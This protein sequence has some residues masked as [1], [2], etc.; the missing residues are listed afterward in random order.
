MRS[1]KPHK[2][3]QGFLP[4]FKITAAF[5]L[6]LTGA[7][8]KAGPKILPLFNASLQGGGSYFNDQSTG[9]KGTGY[10]EFVPVLEFSDRFAL[11]PLVRAS[12]SGSQTAIRI[13]DEQTL[14]EQEQATQVEMGG[15]WRFASDWKLAGA[16]G[17]A[18][19]FLKETADETWG[20]GLYDHRHLYANLAVERKFRPWGRPSL[21]RVGAELAET[22]F[23]NYETL[24]SQVGQAL[25]G[26]HT[27]DV[28]STQLFF[29]GES[30]LTGR[31]YSTYDL[32]LTV[33]DYAD[34]KV[35]TPTGYSNDENRQDWRS[36][37]RGRLDFALLPKKARQLNVGMELSAKVRD[38][39]QNEL[40]PVRGDFFAG[41]YD[42]YEFAA[43]PSVMLRWDRSR[44]VLTLGADVARRQYPRRP[45]QNEAGLSG[46]EDLVTWLTTGHL[47]FSIPVHGNLRAVTS[48]QRVWADS[49]TNYQGFYTYDYT[50]FSYLAGFSY[51]Y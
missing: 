46:S 3:I 35:V 41:Y 40:D 48:V 13:I 24:A 38:S 4:L 17:G 29:R 50:S 1:L 33:D 16:A 18:A 10:L 22:R 26:T 12:Y 47:Q 44:A 23:P 45:A 34:Q 9:F 28:R 39:N 32:R 5:L 43:A 2:Q 37:V 19:T 14:F 36:L 20:D 31:L 51:A 30:A 7:P 8:A 42:Y 15:T 27:L 49:N 25:A 11:L 21:W 6:G